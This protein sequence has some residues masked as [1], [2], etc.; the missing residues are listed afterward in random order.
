MRPWPVLLCSYSSTREEKKHILSRKSLISAVN[1]TTQNVPLRKIEEAAVTENA[2]A[3]VADCR[4]Y[5]FLG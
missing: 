2:T 3:A 4:E 1:T 5:Y